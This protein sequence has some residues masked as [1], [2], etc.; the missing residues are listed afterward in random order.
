ML[1][2]IISWVVVGS[3][4]V[5]TT[6]FAADDVKSKASGNTSDDDLVG[7]FDAPKKEEAAPAA[8]VET[9]PKKEGDKLAVFVLE[10]GWYLSTDL[11]V[12]F[13]FG[14][15]RGYSST[16][17]YMMLKAGYD[18]TDYL[19]I[20]LVLG[21]GFSADN[22]A[23]KAQGGPSN[24]GIYILNPELVYSLRP[25]ERLEIRLRAGAG[26]A[27]LTPAPVDPN[28][29]RNGTLSAV[30]A[31]LSGGVDFVYLTLL[32]DFSAGVSTTG[33]YVMG[34]NVTALS[35]GAFLK[36]TF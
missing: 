14:G 22:A 27:I 11:G 35:A 26:M 29:P 30:N 3:L 21:A 28:N 1:S 34:P 5:S 36:Y 25:L 20:Q 8:K 6:A 12:F 33:Y 4:L 2:K 7:N 13:T 17:P 24:Y 16:Q 31:Q 9:A 19:A 10:K 32:T 18:I 23:N 15:S